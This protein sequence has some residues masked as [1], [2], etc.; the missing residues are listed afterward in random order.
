[1]DR[2]H[3]ILPLPLPPELLYVVFS[4]MSASEARSLRLVC[5]E[6]AD[7]GAW[8]GF[9]MLIIHIYEPDFSMLCHFARHPAISKSVQELVYVCHKLPRP[10][11][12]NDPYISLKEYVSNTTNNELRERVLACK[13]N[14]LPDDAAERDPMSKQDVEENYRRYKCAVKYQQ[15]ILSTKEDYRL[16]KEVIPKFTNL[17]SIFVCTDFL[18]CWSPFKQFFVHIRDS[19]WPQ[20]HRPMEVIMN[21]LKESGTQIRSLTCARADARSFR[22]NFINRIRTVYE[23]LETMHFWFESKGDILPIFYPE[24]QGMHFPGTQQRT[25]SKLLEALPT[26]KNLGLFFTQPAYRHAGYAEFNNIVTPR[27]KWENLGMVYLHQVKADINDLLDFF[28]LHQLTLKYI[29]LSHC[30]LSTSSWARLL[31][32]MKKAMKLDRIRLSKLLF[33]DSEAVGNLSDPTAVLTDQR[34]CWDFGANYEEHHQTQFLSDINEW[35]VHDGPCPLTPERIDEIRLL[36]PI[37][38]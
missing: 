9:R 11:R 7:I 37:D 32:E 34:E 17:K 12:S 21:G 22:K 10:K 2:Q 31:R 13:T 1:M 18:T 28:Q 8:H 14:W 23:G 36:L 33:G 30:S 3:Q 35:F 4:F 15:Y 29:A 26:L 27:F 19:L 38:V 24:A 25:I 20:C 16:F 5:S 6:F